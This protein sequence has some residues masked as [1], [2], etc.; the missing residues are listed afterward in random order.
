MKQYPEIS[1]SYEA[2]AEKRNNSGHLDEKTRRM[3]K[4][5]IAI[6]LNSEGAVRSHARRALNEGASPEEIRQV[7]LLAFTTIGFPNMIAAYKWVDEVISKGG[8]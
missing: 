5:G 2:L 8:K 1:K 7:V 3:V 4:L 6:G